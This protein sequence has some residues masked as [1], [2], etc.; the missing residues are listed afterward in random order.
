MQPRQ[1]HNVPPLASETRS[2]NDSPDNSYSRSPRSKVQLVLSTG[3]VF[4]G[5]LIGAPLLS[6]GE[7][8]FT[9]AMVGYSEA[10]TDPSYFGQILVFT[11]PLIGNYGVPKLSDTRGEFATLGF[12]S[13]RVHASAVIVS[14]DSRECFHYTQNESFHE[15]LLKEG[16]PG[17]VGLDTRHL[18]HLMREHGSILAQVIP[19]GATGVRMLGSINPCKAMT[20]EGAV[21]NGIGAGFFDPGSLNIIKEVSTPKRYTLG[22]GKAK[23]AVLDC[24]VKWN[25]LRQL[26]LHG[27][28]VEV[29]PW[30]TPLADVDCDGWLLSNGPG[31]PNLTGNIVPQIRE[32]LKKTRPILGI[33]LGHQLLGLA[34][35]ATTEKMRYG[36]RSHNQPVREMRTKRGYMSSQNHGHVLVGDVPLPQDWEVWFENINDNTIEGIRHQYKPMMSIQFHPES[37]GGPRDTGWIIENFVEEVKKSCPS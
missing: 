24:G 12:E 32:L 30:D 3:D 9:T 28:Q 19:V 16:V 2:I 31:N 13:P 37:A 7:L 29:V 15:W 33:C 17:I 14:E 11:Y 25:I 18:V 5:E 8:V 20:S 22:K 21:D 27:A 26:I 10:L 34:L 36:H 1:P 4:E 6:S 23:I 35:G